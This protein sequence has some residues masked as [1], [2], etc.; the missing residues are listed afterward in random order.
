MTTA[1]PP[2]LTKKYRMHE[3]ELRVPEAWQ[4]QSMQLFRVPSATGGGDAS[5]IVT[6]DYAAVATP[7][8]TYAE[9][10]VVVLKQKFRG[11]KLLSTGEL[12]IG[13]VAAQ[14]IDYEWESNDVILRQR[15]AYLPAAE[16]MLT[17]TLT[18]RA[19]GFDEL[20]WA[21]Q[22]V[23][24]SLQLHKEPAKHDPIR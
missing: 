7:V 1:P 15:Q 19:R 5:F 2:P 12:A 23:V 10:Q 16:S 3:A 21:W 17:L 8:K 9:E 6:R 22:T 14:L 4:D 13:G 20:E 24:S 11:F 18:A